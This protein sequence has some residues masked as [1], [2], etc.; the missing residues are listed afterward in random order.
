M[1]RIIFLIFVLFVGITNSVKAQLDENKAKAM[2]ILN[3][4]SQITWNEEEEEFNIAVFGEGKVYQ[5]LKIMAQAK[6]IHN[7]PV[8]VQLLKRYNKLGT[9]IVPHILFVDKK[10]NLYIDAV[11]TQ[12]LGTKTLLITDRI[13]EPEYTMIN[14]TDNIQGDKPFRINEKVMQ[15]QNFTASKTL[16]KVGGSESVLR[17]LYTD[18]EKQ[19]KAEKAELERQKEQIANQTALLDELKSKIENQK[20]EL[21]EKE[22]LIDAKQS[23]LVQQSAQLEQMRKKVNAQRYELQKNLGNLSK[24]S[25]ALDSQ[26]LMLKQAKDEFISQNERIQKANEELISKQAQ[27]GEIDKLLGESEQTVARQQREKIV[28]SA[29]LGLILILV[30]FIALEYR[31][32]KKVNRLLHEQNININTQK[33]EIQSI[34]EN[35][36]HQTLVIEASNRELAAK[37]HILQ[38]N[39]EELQ[40]VLAQVSEQKDLIEQKNEAITG[41]INYAKRIQDAI[42]SNP[43]LLSSKFEDAFVYYKPHSIISGDFYW[44]ATDFPKPGHNIIIAA[45]CTGH[46]VPGAFMTILGN[47]LLDQII[48]SEKIYDPSII[49]QELDKRLVKVLKKDMNASSSQFGVNDGM[50]LTVSVFDTENKTITFAGAKNPVLIF[51]DTELFEMKG[52]IFPV[53][54]QELRKGI[55]KTFDNQVFN[56]SKGDMY[57]AFSDG[58]QDQLGGMANRKFMRERYYKLLKAISKLPTNKQTDMLNEDHLSWKGSNEQT[59]DILIIGVKL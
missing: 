18:I 10:E 56:Y 14:F 57:F 29:L 16:L 7:K 11:L 53:G 58:F 6:T 8:K 21:S 4:A 15:K 51:R 42:L 39:N 22:K 40:T 1:N 47:T 45:D 49:L 19:L 36:Q 25:A 38:Q 43:K 17:E 48:L 13:H 44:F 5:E 9:S 26:Q 30:I 2:W 35:L 32:K 24:Q 20:S 54:G 27:I 34:N 12:I 50:D 28:L 31:K 33:E 59:D 3:I 23:E 46:G 52:A 37:E 55:E 41:S